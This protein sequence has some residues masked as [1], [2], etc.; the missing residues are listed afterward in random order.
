MATQVFTIDGE[1]PGLNEIIDAAKASTQKYARIKRECHWMV[2]AGARGIKP[3]ERVDVAVTWYCKNR[4][5]DK[6]NIAAGI[7]YILDGLQEC[8]VLENDGWKQINDITHKFAVDELN[9]RVEVELTEVS[10]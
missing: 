2:A 3:V 5:K 1:L 8:G 6:D 9:P 4:R 10:E 7:K